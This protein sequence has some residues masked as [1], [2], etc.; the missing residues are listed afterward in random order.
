VSGASPFHGA[1]YLYST[2]NDGLREIGVCHWREGVYA[3][4]WWDDEAR[5]PAFRRL[6]VA[7]PC[8]AVAE[9]V[10]RALDVWAHKRELDQW[11][12]ASGMEP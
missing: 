4:G 11:L 3:V 5:P 7:V 8:S 12:D 6:A 10:Q 9:A 1:T 2:P